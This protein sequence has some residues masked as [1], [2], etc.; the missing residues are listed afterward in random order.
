M[1]YSPPPFQPA[2]PKA[3]NPL[4][5]I[6]V[7]LGGLALLCFGGIAFLGWMGMNA[8]NNSI[9]PYGMCEANMSVVRK[10][11]QD[12]AV[13][14]GNKLPSAQAWQDEL[15]PYVEKHIKKLREEAKDTGPL[16]IPVM[17]VNKPWGCDRGDKQMT[18]F[19]FN[20]DVSG[21]SVDKI[22][23]R[24]NTPIIF[25]VELPAENAN[26]KYQRLDPKTSGKIFNETR[27]WGIITW[28]G[29]RFDGSTMDSTNSSF[30]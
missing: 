28:N 1:S 18:G 25:E 16:R 12:Y 2:A 29:N 10:A 14:H 22:P 4:V 8:L 26:M 30:D 7:I 17:D 20:L 21:I 13:D 15:R 19:A 27:G 11:M 23:D 24:D 5:I 9:L 3:K 6:L